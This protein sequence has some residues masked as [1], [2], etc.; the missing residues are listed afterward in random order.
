MTQPA[1]DFGVVLP[2]QEWSAISPTSTAVLIAVVAAMAMGAVVAGW[3]RRRRGRRPVS[4]VIALT[5]AASI[6]AGIYLTAE[7]LPTGR[8]TFPEQ[9][10]PL[11]A[12]LPGVVV[13]S[14]PPRVDAREAAAL[15]EERYGLAGLDITLSQ[16][17][18]AITREVIVT[19]PEGQEQRCALRAVALVD[20]DRTYQRAAIMCGDRELPTAPGY[21]PEARAART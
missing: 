21:R 10:P 9:N 7:M 12:S 5:G 2:S 4:W 18:S 16:N 8:I 17:G 15:L 3:R 14:E 11:I 1:P 20:G 13:E 6:G 19:G